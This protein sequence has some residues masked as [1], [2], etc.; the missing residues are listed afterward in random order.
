MAEGQRGIGDKYKGGASVGDE[1]K[2]RASIGEVNAAVSANWR[3]ST[4]ITRWLR[5]TGRRRTCLTSSRRSSLYRLLRR[6]QREYTVRDVP[7]CVICMR[8]YHMHAICVTLDYECFDVLCRSPIFALR[9]DAPMLEPF[10]KSTECH[11]VV[12]EGCSVQRCHT[13]ALNG[14]HCPL[15]LYSS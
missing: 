15:C 3:R 2:G 4:P 12:Q 7:A 5:T 10:P 8:A 6:L 13:E 1:Y 9:L 11:T 14:K